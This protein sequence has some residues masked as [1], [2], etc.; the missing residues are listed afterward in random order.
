MNQPKLTEQELLTGQDRLIASNRD[1][2][3]ICEID[4]D[5]IRMKYERTF[6]KTAMAGS[7]Q[8][9]GATESI[10]RA[11]K[12]LAV[13]DLENALELYGMIE[14]KLSAVGDK[15][16]EEPSEEPVEP[17]QFHEEWKHGEFQINNFTVV[18]SGTLHVDDEY[19]KRGAVRHWLSQI[20]SR[21]S[22][23]MNA[24]LEDVEARVLDLIAQSRAEE[25]AD[26]ESI[27]RGDA[28]KRLS[29]S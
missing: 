11:K 22:E 1:S 24:G 13:H 2:Q 27:M 4:G 7:Y 8:E 3:L 23:A 16:F 18:S 6:P 19:S 15:Y 5:E 21:Q 10:Q 25:R 20:V 29:D 9:D 28:L 26:Y 12:D 17:Y 14:S